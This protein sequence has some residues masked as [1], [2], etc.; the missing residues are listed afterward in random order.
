MQRAPKP[1]WPRGSR[2]P[3]IFPQEL[4]RLDPSTR[5]CGDDSIAS[6]LPVGHV[7]L[8]PLARLLRHGY[9][10]L[11][12][13]LER[14]SLSCRC[15]RARR[16]QPRAGRSASRIGS[17]RPDPYGSSGTAPT[18]PRR[19]CAGFPS[20]ASGGRVTR[21]VDPFRVE[22]SVLVIGCGVSA[23][24]DHAPRLRRDRGRRA[25]AEL[26]RVRR[27]LRVLRVAGRSATGSSSPQCDLAVAMSVPTG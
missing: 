3:P 27:H 24:R 11:V 21:Q 10:E 17:R 5:T 8:G 16:E 22:L 2:I 7:L 19:G 4:P 6:A 9:P 14:P 12:H 25:G 13:P 23:P 26:E 15:A 18:R 1:T 20:S